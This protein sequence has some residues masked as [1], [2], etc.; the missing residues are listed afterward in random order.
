MTRRQPCLLLAA[1]CCLLA[2][3]TSA[4]AECAWVVW[5]MSQIRNPTRPELAT[6]IYN[7]M[8]ANGTEAGCRE[9]SRKMG[10]T[11]DPKNSPVVM[12]YCLPNTVDPRG[13]KGK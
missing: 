1:L 6:R 5:E 2:F 9:M 10:E 3:V 7:I 13:P 4:S 8:G 11:L 12:Y